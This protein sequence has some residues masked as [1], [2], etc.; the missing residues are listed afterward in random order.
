[1]TNCFSLLLILFINIWGIPQQGIGLPWSKG[2]PNSKKRLLLF[3][4]TIDVQASSLF[5]N[6]SINQTH[7]AR[8]TPKKNTHQSFSRRKALVV[9]Y[10]SS[11][12]CSFEFRAIWQWGHFTTGRK[13]KREKRRK[14]NWTFCLHGLHQQNQWSI[15]SYWLWKLAVHNGEIGSAVHYI[16]GQIGYDQKPFIL[17]T[18]NILSTVYWLARGCSH[19]KMVWSTASHVHQWISRRIS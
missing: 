7:D 18:V 1:M 8:C 11:F 17:L 13:D 9:D 14:S 2:S 3:Q 19:W 6:W 16:F 10:R 15:K 12:L 4:S 5:F